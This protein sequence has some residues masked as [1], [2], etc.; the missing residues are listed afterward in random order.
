MPKIHLFRP[1]VSIQYQ[2]WAFDRQTTNWYLAVHLRCAVKIPCVHEQVIAGIR[3]EKSTYVSSARS[4]KKSPADKIRRN[5][6]SARS[7][8]VF[9]TFTYARKSRV[10][11]LSQNL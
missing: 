3:D 10:H 7:A 4:P 5:I 1:A 6:S 8:S 2:R 9:V 11:L